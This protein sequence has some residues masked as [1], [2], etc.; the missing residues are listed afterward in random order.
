M[1]WNDIEK[2]WI[3]LL[4]YD[5]ITVNE[6]NDVK[7]EH[8]ISDKMNEKNGRERGERKTNVRKCGRGWW[9][10]SIFQKEWSQ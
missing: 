1:L 2:K 10:D 6:Y 9:D 7:N 4:S 5:R 3:C 8:G